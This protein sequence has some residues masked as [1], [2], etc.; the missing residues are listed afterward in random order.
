MNLGEVGG[1]PV[2]VLLGVPLL[3]IDNRVRSRRWRYF[4]RENL[5]GVVGLIVGVPKVALGANPLAVT[6]PEEIGSLGVSTSID[7]WKDPKLS[8]KDMAIDKASIDTRKDPKD[9]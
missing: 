1:V 4:N 7:P 6:A 3:V 2:P 5:N 9:P 8:R